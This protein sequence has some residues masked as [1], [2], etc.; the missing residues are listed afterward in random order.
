MMMSDTDTRK[1]LRRSSSESFE[2]ARAAAADSGL[3]GEA[4]RVTEDYLD[5]IKRVDTRDGLFDDPLPPEDDAPFA[6]AG[7]EIPVAGPADPGP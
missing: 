4:Q 5:V 6:P 3:M 1:I 7:R 2:E